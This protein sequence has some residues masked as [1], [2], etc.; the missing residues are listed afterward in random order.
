MAFVPA[1][2]PAANMHIRHQRKHRQGFTLIE[3]IVVIAVLGILA[4]V[5]LPKFV[6]LGGDARVATM[7][8]AR[9][10]LNSAAA[11]IHA[12]WLLK[13]GDKVVVEGIEVEIVNGYPRASMA[14]AAAAGLDNPGYRVEVDKDEMIVSPASLD[15][16]SPLIGTCLLTYSAPTAANLPPT[17][18][19]ARDPLLCE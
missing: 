6:G 9:G 17:I 8:A 15:D 7:K 11:I 12:Q 13:P 4:A 16:S 14:F 2:F 3:L 1:D 19:A 5:A 10:A 18:R